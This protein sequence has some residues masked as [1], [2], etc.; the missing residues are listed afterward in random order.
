MTVFDTIAAVSTPRGKGG[1]AVIR[2]SGG[3]TRAILAR[4]FV[5]KK[6]PVDHPRHAI[7][8]KICRN[9]GEV[10]DEG[11]AVYF[12]APASFTGE[13]VAEISCHGGSLLTEAVLGAVLAAGARPARAG[14]FTARA[15][16]N[17]KMALT[18]AEA[19]G[20][21][22]EAATED[23]LS[24][25]RGGMEGKLS[26]AIRAIYG[27]LTAVQADVFARID[28]PEE[29]LGEL[30]PEELI[31]ALTRIREDLFTLSRTWKTGHAVGEGVRTVICGPANAGKST[32]YNAMVGH[33]AAIV[34]D[35]AGTTRDVLTE[36]VAFGGVTLRLF[37]TAG[38]RETTDKVEQIGIARTDKALKEAELV[39]A[40]LDGSKELSADATA[41]LARLKALDA[42]VIV[43]LNK[44]DADRRIAGSA[45]E[46][47]AHVVGISAKTGDVTPLSALIEGLYRADGIDLRHD[48]VVANARQYAALTR[49][50][51]ALDAALGS[52]A[53]GFP[54]D[55]AG[56]ELEGALTALGEVDA[57][58]V[59]EDVIADI[60]SRFCVGK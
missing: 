17:G 10:L 50:I 46:G 44:Q 35:I 15:V 16:S 40:V 11:L 20:D 52:L 18:E 60:F 24:L 57:R 38:L 41:F 47:F 8:G 29:D 48:P 36:T 58:T 43:V 59:G 51:A 45:L 19:L 25:A 23:Q 42:T 21:L 33:D 27:Q 34:T 12:P 6:S 22:L 26:G 54:L 55:A 49:A 39:L 14:E 56:A 53:A 13:D 30:S 32:L 3:D 1:I 7:F 37:D 2:I 28:F 4:V 31:A 5:A 9:G